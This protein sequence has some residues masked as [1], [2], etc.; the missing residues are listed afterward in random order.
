MDETLDA[1]L[2]ADLGQEGGTIYVH[3]TERKVGRLYSTTLKT[4]IF[5]EYLLPTT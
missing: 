5:C 3:V 1:H 2:L 4:S